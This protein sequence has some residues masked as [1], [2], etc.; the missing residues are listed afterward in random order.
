M[1]RTIPFNPFTIKVDGTPIGR[2][3]PVSDG[4]EAWYNNAAD[5]RW[6][7]GFAPTLDSAKAQLLDYHAQVV[8]S[9][10]R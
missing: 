6:A 5:D 2:V 8:S 4:W 10:A 3:V 7:L 1:R 9:R